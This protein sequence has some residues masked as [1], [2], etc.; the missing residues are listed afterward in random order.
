MDLFEQVKKQ[1]DQVRQ[2]KADKATKEDVLAAVDLL[3]KLKLEFKESTGQDYN[4]DSPPDGSV[5][6]AKEK[7]DEGFMIF[8]RFIFSITE[9]PAGDVVT[10]WDV[11]ATDDK[12]VDYAKLIERFGSTPISQELLDRCEKLTGKKVHRFLRR[13]IFFSHREFEQILGQL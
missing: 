5:A 8:P 6:E 11:Q 4:A 9:K 3:K 1:G 7:V 13:G 12:G 10:P 2:L